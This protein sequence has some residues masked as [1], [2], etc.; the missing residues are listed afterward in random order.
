MKGGKTMSLLITGGAGYI[1][2]HTLKYFTEKGKEVVVVDNLETGHKEFVRDAIFYNLD[3]R[4][5]IELD[6]LFK[7]HDIEGVIHFAANSIVGESMIDPYKY[8]HNNV[9]GM[10][11][12]LDVM[13]HNNV[14]KIVFSSTAA[15]YGEPREIPISE[16]N[17]TLPTNPYGETKLA[18]E[19]MMHWFDV[20]YGIKYV[21]LRYFNAAGAIEDSSIGELHIPETHLIPLILQ[22]PLGQKDRV[23][24]F[25]DDYPT[26]DGTCIRDYVHVMDLASAHYLAYNYLLEGNESQVFNLGNEIGY[27]VFEVINTAKKVTGCKIPVE[28]IGRRSGDP[29][30]LIA[31]S[32]K[33]KD[34]LNWEL[35]Y[36]SLEKIIK[37]AWEFQK[38]YI[39]K[40]KERN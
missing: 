21:S 18:M 16:D 30:A 28:V 23:Y 13:K 4:N 1:G 32:K 5:K 6:K 17:P 14:K 15:V 27:T 25:G 37:D 29:A 12:L 7:K 26:K 24:V 2:S 39:N 36:S 35:K 34:T 22:V 9:Y 38:N 31:S 8:Y 11:C 33:I 40:W 10:L 19:R 20:A 3:I